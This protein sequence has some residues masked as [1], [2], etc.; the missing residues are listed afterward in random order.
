M[1]SVKLGP[2]DTDLSQA[3]GNMVTVIFMLLKLSVN[4]AIHG[5]N[6][7][8]LQSTDIIIIIIIIYIGLAISKYLT[9]VPIYVN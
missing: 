2:L 3:T 9:R 5:S 4:C 8:H 6:K 1:K 7:I